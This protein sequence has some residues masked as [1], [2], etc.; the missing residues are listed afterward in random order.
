MPDVPVIPEPEDES[1]AIETA[2]A[3]A[4]TLTRVAMTG[5]PNGRVRRKVLFLTA[6]LGILAALVLDGALGILLGGLG[7]IA[8]LLLAMTD[9]VVDLS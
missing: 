1:T 8:L 5:D 3:K 9:D 4:G 7:L 2:V 6:A